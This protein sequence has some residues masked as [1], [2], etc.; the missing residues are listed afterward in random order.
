MTGPTQDP[1]RIALPRVGETIEGRYRL[2]EALA[3]GGM[4]V[5]M[6]AE[7][8]MMGRD[9]AVKLLHPHIASQA[10]FTE[11]FKRE[12]RVSTLFTHPNI[13][14][15][16]DFGETADGTLY[17][18]MELLE[19]RE[20]KDL[21]Q[22]EGPL[23]VGRTI[24]LGLQILDGLAEA[25]SSGVIHRDLKP[26]N[27][28]VVSNRRGQESIKLLDFGIARL[29]DA[30]EATLTGTGMIAGTPSYMAPELLLGEPPSRAV[31]VYAV[32]LI[33]LE[34]LTGQ[35]I[36]DGSTMAQNLLMQL[37]RPVPIPAAIDRIPLGEVLRKAT[38]KHP[39]DRY[40]DAEEMLDA[41]HKAVAGSPG[42][43][44]LQPRQIPAPMSAS[45]PDPM[46]QLALH[47]KG[48][49]I[50]RE[51]PQHESIATAP[52]SHGHTEVLAPGDVE[53]LLGAD[54]ET[55]R[56][57]AETAVVRPALGT[58]TIPR[59]SPESSPERVALKNEP[60]EVSGRA[61]LRRGHGFTWAL[62]GVA[63]GIVLS[64]VLAR[65]MWGPDTSVASTSGSDEEVG[66]A[67]QKAAVPVT[68]IPVRLESIPEGASV[69]MGD[70]LRGQTSLSLELTP[71]A[72][73]VT[74][75]LELEG[76]KPQTVEL[77]AAPQDTVVV[78]LEPEAARVEEPAR[79][80][81][82]KPAR[83]SSPSRPVSSPKP[84]PSSPPKKAQDPI[85]SVLDRY[86][87]EL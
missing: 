6:R 38:C 36:F 23:S 15:V 41:L 34:M 2:K 8:A 69:F 47:G 55:M 1:R 86:L 20:L 73:P 39:A 57:D 42:E 49:E 61:R 28:F 51:A 80:V 64:L 75:R 82:K 45:A 37:K 26:S 58:A 65:F 46:E 83:S 17:L 35:R 3:S 13:T 14:R 40:G 63:V 84:A 48:L 7:H 54:D 22:A 74:V 70:V 81:A 24:G 62:G 27:I 56:R 10:G 77:E 43:L 33:L 52:P 12:V 68:T 50:L 4:G 72:L 11:R 25:H 53:F 30:S 31:D 60:H 9:V 44:R 21:V 29:T 59:S 71:D 5:V 87:P 85:D 66:A 19:G 32:G 18:V 78:R 76:F 79:E 67:Q 16:Y